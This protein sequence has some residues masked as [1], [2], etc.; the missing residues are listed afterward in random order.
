M[1]CW[2][3]VSLILLLA[4]AI[5][6]P[7]QINVIINK[8]ALVTLA[9]YLGYLLHRS[10]CPYARPRELL[11]H[12]DHMNCEGDP[13]NEWHL[14]LGRLATTAILAR[15]IIMAAAMLAVALGI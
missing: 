1:T 5:I 11:E 6:A 4:V 8:V 12:L 14:L 7:Q 2:L 3:G 9:A 15:A 13:P 10:V